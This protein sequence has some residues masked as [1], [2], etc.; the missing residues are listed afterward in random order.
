MV[1]PATELTSDGCDHA[2][3][4][5]SRLMERTTPPPASWPTEVGEARALPTYLLVNTDSESWRALLKLAGLVSG[6]A[7]SS[8]FKS[9]TPNNP[10]GCIGSIHSAMSLQEF[11]KN[12]MY[13]FIWLRWVLFV[14]LRILHLPF[15]IQT[16]SCCVWESSSLTREQTQAPC[17]GS[18]ES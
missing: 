2:S 5:V 13:L 14:A 11:K 16:L 4:P 10:T 6:R 15:S 3:S 1:V 12:F 18:K 17:L 9:A 8:V 7:G